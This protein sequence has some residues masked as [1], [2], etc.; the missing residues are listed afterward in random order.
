LARFD[1]GWIFTP[2]VLTNSLSAG[3]FEV[4]AEAFSGAEFDPEVAYVTGVG[5]LIRY[6]FSS[7]THFVPFIELGAGTSLTDIG[8]PDL[9]GIF[10]F[11][12]QGGLGAHLFLSPRS[13]LTFTYRFLH[14][15]NA[16]ISAPNLGV[17]NHSFSLG[18]SR[19]F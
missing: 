16:G 2:Q 3:H 9:S 10:Q 18:F 4:L 8:E 12:L 7:H 19:F 6:N 1:F 5:P 15:S 14:I 17:N 13:A 11:H